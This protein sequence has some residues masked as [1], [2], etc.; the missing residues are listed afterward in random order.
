MKTRKI[1][2]LTLAI[3]LFSFVHRAIDAFSDIGNFE[4]KYQKNGVTVG[5]QINDKSTGVAI[6]RAFVKIINNGN[7]TVD[8][9]PDGLLKGDGKSAEARP[10]RTL[11]EP[12]R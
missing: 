1:T 10:N 3:V 7:Q 9:L 5:I 11:R 4:G 8:T 2:F 6:P 12:D